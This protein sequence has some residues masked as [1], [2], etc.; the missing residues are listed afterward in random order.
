[1][2]MHYNVWSGRSQ[3]HLLNAATGL[4]S[5]EGMPVGRSTVKN[6][7]ARPHIRFLSIHLQSCG[8]RS[9]DQLNSIL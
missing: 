8:K 9:E 3:P 2:M 7:L 1:M 4:V 6:H 5:E